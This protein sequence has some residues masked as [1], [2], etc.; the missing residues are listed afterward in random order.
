MLCRSICTLLFAAVVSLAADPPG[1]DEWRYDV[2]HFKSGD[3]LRRPGA[4]ADGD[5]GQG[6]LHLAKP[7]KVTLLIT[8]NVPRVEIARMELLNDDDRKQLQHR[9]DSLK[10]KREV[11]AAHLR[12]LD[13]K[14]KIS[15]KAG[16]IF[17]LR[18][19]AW[20]DD[21][22]IKALSYQSVHFHLIANARPE[23]VKLAAIHLEQAYAAYARALPPRRRRR[24]HHD[25]F[26]AISG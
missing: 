10:R 20:P 17:D 11:L 23:L 18:P 24:H 19:V 6:P 7:G 4:G 8:E 15:G 26:D 12:S 1:A 13:P 21:K 25:P 22:K 16:D 9:L 5:D 2:I 14:M 3:E